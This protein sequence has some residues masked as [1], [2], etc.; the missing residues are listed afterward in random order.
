M[1]FDKVM[2]K[3]NPWIIRLLESRCHGLL[4]YAL[5]V[6]HVKGVKSGKRYSI[7]V[8]YQKEGSQIKVLVSK[9]RRKNWWRNYRAEAPIDLTLK[10]KTL[11]GKASLLDKES[12]QFCNFVYST[13]E[14]VPGLSKQFGIDH[15]RG[16]QLSAVEWKTVKA[17]SEVVE[18]AL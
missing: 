5:M 15:V 2:T 13:F 9:S 3:L 18:I 1:D 16:A 4:S 8:G 17:D 6:V 10:G 14:R 12:E 11:S 7:P